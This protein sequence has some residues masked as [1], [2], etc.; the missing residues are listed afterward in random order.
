MRLALEIEAHNE[1]YYQKDAP[2][3]SD[4]DYD[5]LRQRCDAIEAQF[6][7]LVTADSPSQKVGAAPSRRLRQGPARRADAVARQC[8]QRRGRGRL[9][10]SH[11]ALSQ[12]RRRRDS[13]AS[14]PSRRSTGCRCRCAT[15][16]ANWSAPRRAATASTGEDV[17]ANVRT[18]KDIPQKLKG[19]NIPDVVRGA[20]RSLYAQDGLSRAQQAAG[21][22]RRARSS[23]IRAIRRRV[24]CARRTSSITASRPLHFFAYAWGE[25]SAHAGRY[26]DRHDRL[27]RQAAASPINPLIKLCEIVERVARVLPRDRASSAPRSAT[28]STASSTRSTGSTGRS[29]S[30]SSRAAPRWAIAHK[31]AAEHAT[32]VLDDID[33]QVGRTGALTPVARARA[34]HGRRRRRAERDAAQR[35]LHQG[36]RQ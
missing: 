25:M 23:P 8:L 9:R 17:T 2:S 15:R 36:H 32:T 4:A 7:E 35:G 13:G 22:G 19:R 12:A 26:P 27:A 33:I 6:P 28:T 20:R 11:P 29:G 34:G 14:S 31:F 10:R 1:R 16:T 3:V 5:A 24:R 21:R 30:A 18:M